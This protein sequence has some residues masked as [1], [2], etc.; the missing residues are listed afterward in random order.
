VGY[1]KFLSLS[2][3]YELYIAPSAASSHCSHTHTRQQL[4]SQKTCRVHN[5]LFW[6]LYCCGSYA[7]NFRQ[8]GLVPRREHSLGDTKLLF[9]PLHLFHTEDS[10]NGNRGNTSVTSSQQGRHLSGGRNF[11]LPV[12]PRLRVA[13][14]LVSKVRISISLWLS[15]TETFHSIRRLTL[16]L[17]LKWHFKT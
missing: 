16:T 13:L 4:T 2:V 17:P 5:I 12:T 3:L 11:I 1:D 14:H 9:G 15:Q 7:N 8:P 10:K 6:L